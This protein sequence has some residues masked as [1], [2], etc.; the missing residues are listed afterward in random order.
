MQLAEGN[1]LTQLSGISLPARLELREGSGKRIEAIYGDV[2]LTHRGLSGPAV[3]DMSRH[4]LAASL[5]NPAGLTANWLPDLSTEALEE[6]LQNLGRRTVR[7]FLRPLLPDRLVDHLLEAALIAPEQTGVDLTRP[8]RKAL[9]TAVGA[10]PL[11]V[12]GTQGFKVAEVTAGGVPL[13][14]IDLKRMESRVVS[15][16][17]L[18]GE[19]CDVDGRIGGFN[20][21]WAWS[22]GYVAGVSA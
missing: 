15:G 3:L 4:W 18:C 12:S 22:S 13:A 5:E 1:P 8:Q 7:S 14:Q 19:I 10:Y 21:Q 2:L 17:H 9:M 6:E 20:F 16:L 11:A